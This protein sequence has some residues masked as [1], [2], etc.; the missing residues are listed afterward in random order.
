M[1]TIRHCMYDLFVIRLYT[2]LLV[3]LHFLVVQFLLK[4]IKRLYF[5]L[6]VND[7][8]LL[9]NSKMKIALKLLYIPFSRLHFKMATACCSARFTTWFSRLRP[10]LD[11]EPGPSSWPPLPISRCQRTSNG[12]TSS[13]NTSRGENITNG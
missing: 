13:R 12:T 4:I 1:R 11:W 3:L 6:R 5:C 9:W 10:R 8:L 2:V 7:K